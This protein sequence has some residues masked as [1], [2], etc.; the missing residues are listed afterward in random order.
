MESQQ[1]DTTN[2]DHVY[3]QSDRPSEPGSMSPRPEQQ[4]KEPD[5]TL[6]REVQR[7]QIHESSNDQYAQPAQGAQASIPG[8]GLEKADLDNLSEVTPPDKSDAEGSSVQQSSAVER[9]SPLP[10]HSTV[11]SPGCMSSTLLATQEAPSGFMFPR[12]DRR[13]FRLGGKR[14]ESIQSVPHG[15][16]PPANDPPSQDNE[17]NSKTKTGQASSSPVLMAMDGGTAQ[18]ALT[19]TVHSGSDGD[20]IDGQT[21][22][23]S[24]NPD[25]GAQQHHAQYQVD[26]QIIR[27][28]SMSDG[29]EQELSSE[30]QSDDAMRLKANYAISYTSERASVPHE[31]TYDQVSP[32]VGRSTVPSRQSDFADPVRDSI[33]RRTFAH[34]PKPTPDLRLYPNAVLQQPRIHASTGRPAQ[35]VTALVTSPDETQDLLDVVAY[36]FREKEQSLQRA[37]STDQRKMQSE[38]QQAYTENE[39]LRSQVA[40]FEEQCN[41]SE[42]VIS[43]YR[44]QIGKAK[45]L[46]K[47]LDG[48]GNDLHNLKRS[49]ELEKITFAVRIEASETEIERLQCSLAGKDEFEI[50][51]SHSKITLEK[52]IDAKSFELQSV[53]Q[54]RDMLRGQL[55]ERIGQLVEERD[56][57]MRLEHLIGQL[58]LDGRVSLTA[59]LEQVTTSLL[60]KMAGLDQQG[61]GLAIDI[62]SLHHDVQALTQRRPATL[63]DCK[64]ITAEMHDL[65]LKIAQGLS[66]EATTNTTVADLTGAV[67]GLIQNHMRTLRQELDRMEIAWKESASS[68]H[69]RVALEVELRGA[70]ERLAQ[71]EC[72]LNAVRE[73]E[74]FATDALDKSLTR[75]SELQAVAHRTSMHNS[76]RVTPQDVELKVMTIFSCL[77]ITTNTIEGRRS[78]GSCSKAN[79]RQRQCFH[80]PRKG[81]I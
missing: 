73:S 60:S 22:S 2:V 81:T 34:S 75:V 16:N 30:A 23:Q 42:G 40:A 56:T 77:V 37:F 64:T 10:K 26:E 31:T 9:S 29:L 53:I 67:E 39:T 62:A 41:Q 66:I 80:R 21:S 79:L 52:L 32:P 49:Y 70:H 15:S 51:L 57:R 4:P 6:G 38:L 35:R 74:A 28:A 7:G 68:D 5:L 71:L 45:G 76:A 36:K 61:D 43:K 3:D 78:S 20:P 72:Q 27:E 69:A 47:F 24:I 58:R 13:N 1:R 44:D 55:D 25:Q 14:K 63:D 46:Q 65:G 54:H 12:L 18:S 48:L 11:P 33:A 19:E 8:R 59:S 17:Q 50:M